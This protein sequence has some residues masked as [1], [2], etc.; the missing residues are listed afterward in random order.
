MSSL[1]T[2]LVREDGDVLCITVD[3]FIA[4]VQI[5]KTDVIVA[6]LSIDDG[7]TDMDSRLWGFFSCYSMFGVLY[8]I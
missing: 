8:H 4:H 5:T 3:A 1:K 2:Y 7:L 6:L